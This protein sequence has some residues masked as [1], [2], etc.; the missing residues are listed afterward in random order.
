MDWNWKSGRLFEPWYHF[1]PF[2]DFVYFVPFVVLNRYH[3]A[4]K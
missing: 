4:M 2:F 3:Q 1:N